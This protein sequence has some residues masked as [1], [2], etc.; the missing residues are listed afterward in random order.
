M[1]LRVGVRP[2]AAAPALDV[3]IRELPPS[4]EMLL[5]LRKL[6]LELML[7]LIPGYFTP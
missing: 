6:P 3:F 4:L 2:E 7:L 1:E 5:W